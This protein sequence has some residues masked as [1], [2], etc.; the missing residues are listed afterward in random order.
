[1]RVVRVVSGEWL[2]VHA[3]NCAFDTK[4]IYQNLPADIMQLSNSS[5]NTDIHIACVIIN[6]VIGLLVDSP[7]N[8]FTDYLFNISKLDKVFLLAAPSSNNPAS[9]VAAK[10]YTRYKCSCGCISNIIMLFVLPPSLF[11]I[12]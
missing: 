12:F 8:P 2:G 6:F 7:T 11:D 5:T 3:C 4:Q 1:V 10:V 9:N